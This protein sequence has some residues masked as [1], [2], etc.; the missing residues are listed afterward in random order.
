MDN[1]QES[2]LS[3]HVMHVMSD[4]MHPWECLQWS[5][6][7]SAGRPYRM[8]ATAFRRLCKLQMNLTDSCECLSHMAL[9]HTG[10]WMR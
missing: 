2:Q 4:A 9:L 10:I 6:W 7:A 5:A 8:L 3:C 1:M